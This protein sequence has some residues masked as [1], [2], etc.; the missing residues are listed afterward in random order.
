MN[1]SA[2]HQTTPFRAEP[3]DA[4][5]LHQ[6]PFRWVM[7]ALLWLLYFSFGMVTRSPSPLITPI[8]ND[9]KMSYGQMGFVLGSWQ[10]TYIVLAI[11]AG[12][13]M[14]RWGIKKSIFVGALII[15]LSAIL[16]SFSTG[17]FTLL[18]FVALF[19]AGGPM[20]S[21]GCP[22]TIA[23]WFKGKDR[24]TAVGIY[25]TGP[26]IGGM[27]CLAATNGVVMPLV[28]NSWR[29]TFV[30]YGTLALVF[31]LLWLFFAKE[32]NPETESERFN[33]VHVLA[34][35][36]RV[37]NVRI[38]LLCGLLSFGIGHGF[39]AWLPKILESKGFSP[40]L[41]GIG[42]ATPFIASIPAVLT[43]PRS[44]PAHFR[45]KIIALLAVLGVMSILWV[46]A[47]PLPP[48]I[49]LLLYGASGTC[50]MPLLVL[51]LMDTPEVASKYLGSATGVFFCV[52][53]IGGFFGPF[54]VGYLVDVTGGFL[55]GSFFLVSLG[56]IILAL[57]LKLKIPSITFEG[58]T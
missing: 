16:R 49:G 3:P 39:S 31:A 53:E 26:W 18:I 20:I 55:T 25:S 23:L 15:G 29:L 38:I 42:A 57:M 13:I 40:I 56:V 14:D 7:L 22:K 4:A 17:F 41:A 47:T 27:T 19:G 5:A 11:M 54:V 2:E 10:M 34:D 37:P 50:L 46:V 1:E 52:A 43:I 33:P 9:L 44:V 12:I 35:L 58:K 21:I 28:D 48:I 6:M 8:I 36:M 30:C 51:T 45:G 32:V 24:G